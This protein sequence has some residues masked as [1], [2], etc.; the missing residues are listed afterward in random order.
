MMDDEGIPQDG[1]TV[2]QLPGE[3]LAA[4]CK[5]LG[6]SYHAAKGRRKRGL[7]DEQVFA[8]HSLRYYIANDNPYALPG[9]SL[10]AT[11][12]RLGVGYDAALD[13]I[14]LGLPADQVF[15]THDRRYRTNDDNPYALHG[16]SLRA[17]CKRLGLP[18][19][20]ILERLRSGL[21]YD[22]VF[23][24][25]DRKSIP[26]TVFGVEHASL[27]EA[28]RQHGIADSYMT[29]QGWIKKGMSPDDAF[30]KALNPSRHIKG[31]VVAFG[32]KYHRVSKNARLESILV[33]GIWAS[34]PSSSLNTWAN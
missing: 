28:C 14:K 8:P 2:Y 31:Q 15:S 20:R 23:A 24:Q 26:V 30:T 18:Y 13:R 1:Q 32:V 5:R 10:A 19:T 9:E 7:P 21:S 29:I 25:Q 6:I 33:P 4:A 11:C 12:K 34:L 17:M 22:E 16:E 27:Q 3:S